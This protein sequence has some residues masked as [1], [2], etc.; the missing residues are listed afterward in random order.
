MI[1]LRT[2]AEGW[3]LILPGAALAIVGI[4]FMCRQKPNFIVMLTSSGG[5]MEAY[6]SQDR[7]FMARVINA[8]HQ[9]IIARG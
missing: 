2:S 3:G 5:E 4:I 6:S 1:D 9:A 8:I 7:D